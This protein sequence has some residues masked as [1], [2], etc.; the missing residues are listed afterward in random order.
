MP[1]SVDDWPDLDEFKALLDVDSSN[2]DDH[3]ETVLTAGIDHV[4]GAVKWVEGTSVVTAKLHNA[5]LRAAIVMRPNGPQ[6][7]PGSPAHSDVDAD[8]AYQ[9]LMK[10]KRRSFGI[11]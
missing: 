4:K 2:F 8:P 11:G 3:L 5:A 9:A 6:P 10:G 7:G 1:V